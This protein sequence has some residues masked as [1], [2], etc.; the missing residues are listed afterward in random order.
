[1]RPEYI[2]K[3]R[4][5]LESEEM[6]KEIGSLKT[7]RIQVIAQK[8][9]AEEALKRIVALE[10]SGASPETRIQQAV[11]LAKQGL[12]KPDE[13]LLIPGIDPNTNPV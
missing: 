5:N 9:Q 8:S 2:A 12:L 6:T 1:M 7:E 11:L 13:I 10:V 3:K 4:A